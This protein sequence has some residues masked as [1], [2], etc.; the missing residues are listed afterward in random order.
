MVTDVQF[1]AIAK[2]AEFLDAE[3]LL[4]HLCDILATNFRELITMKDFTSKDMSYR[5]MHRLLKGFTGNADDRLTILAHWSRDW[6]GDP[7]D[8]RSGGTL[9]PLMRSVEK[10]PAAAFGALDASAMYRLVS[11]L[12]GKRIIL[13]SCSCMTSREGE[14][15]A[16]GS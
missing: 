3:A 13:P 6:D 9:C 1:V 4:D 2:L 11:A 15:S 10:M 7:T 16:V 8:T 14:R 12:A 5:V